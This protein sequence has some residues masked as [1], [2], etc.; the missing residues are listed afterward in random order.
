VGR[1]LV[2]SGQ[3]R[4]IQGAGSQRSLFEGSFL[5]MLA[6][7]GHRTT[8]FHVVTQVGRGVYL[9]FQSCPILGIFLYLCL[10]F[11]AERPNAAW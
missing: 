7:F 3:P 9:E 10:P 2:L 11:N 1:A 5:F 6:S 8:K 4:P